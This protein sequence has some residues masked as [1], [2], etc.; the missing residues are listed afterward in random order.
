MA[1]AEAVVV[2]AEIIIMAGPADP[3]VA[4]ECGAAWAETQIGPI[5]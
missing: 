5:T 2:V 3:G 1:A 4:A